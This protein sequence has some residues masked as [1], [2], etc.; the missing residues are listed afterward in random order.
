MAE[1][2]PLVTVEDYQRALET[3]LDALDAVLGGDPDSEVFDLHGV[4]GAE[5][6]SG[7][8]R[9]ALEEARAAQVLVMELPSSP[10]Y[11]ADVTVG[12]VGDGSSIRVVTSDGKDVVV[13]SPGL[14]TT[15]RPERFV[16]HRG[17]DSVVRV[18]WHVLD[19][20]GRT[21]WS[22]LQESA[23]RIADGSV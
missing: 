4:V 15:V 6:W 13:V 2:K 9:R 5:R 16:E 3:T 20:M 23:Q 8:C 22:V 1:I 19:E 21:L 10:E 12:P 11:G 18:R 7:A 17:E 14:K